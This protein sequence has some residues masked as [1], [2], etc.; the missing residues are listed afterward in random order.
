MIS[1][2]LVYG[3]T[4]KCQLALEQKNFLSAH[5]FQIIQKLEKKFVM[6]RQKPK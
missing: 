4:F 6:F 2:Y 5:Q 3:I 1:L